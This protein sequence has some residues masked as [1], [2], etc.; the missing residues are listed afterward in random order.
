ML[1]TAIAACALRAGS[2]AFG[3]DGPVTI[4]SCASSGV[5]GCPLITS[6]QGTYALYA[7][8]PRPDP[9]KGHKCEGYDWQQSEHLHD[10]TGYQGRELELQ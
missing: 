6:P 8:P 4:N 5:E 1:K 2:A 3:A 9:G 7:S 10:R